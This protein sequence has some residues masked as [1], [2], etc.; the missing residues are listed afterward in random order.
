M[1][2]VLRSAAV[3]ATAGA[4]IYLSGGVLQPVHSTAIKRHP[5]VSAAQA[6][7]SQQLQVSWEVTMHQTQTQIVARQQQEIAAQ[8]AAAA[9][10]AQAAA[11]AQAQ[12]AAQARAQAAAQAQA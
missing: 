4:A 2:P 12:A 7:A 1:F 10:Q 6:Q 8:R 11:A 9:A 3:L 5:R